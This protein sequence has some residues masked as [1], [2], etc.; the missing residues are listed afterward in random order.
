[1]HPVV[2]LVMRSEIYVYER[3]YGLYNRDKSI[4]MLAVHNAN[5]AIE[6]Y[7]N[8]FRA[9]EV[10]RMVTVDGNIEHSEVNIGDARIMNRS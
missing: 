3:T 10:S 5:K 9:V 2:R 4:P 8:V 6:F 1:V 7:K